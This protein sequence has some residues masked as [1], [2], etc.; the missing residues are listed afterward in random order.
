MTDKEILEI[1]YRITSGYTIIDG[2]IIDT[3]TDILMGESIFLYNKIIKDA[4]FEEFIN[5]REKD[6]ILIIN[7]LW[8]FTDD[9]N[10]KELS[11][12]LDNAKIELFK[13]YGMPKGHLDKIRKQIELIREQQ[14]KKTN[15]KHYLDAFTLRGYAEYIS[16][17]DL[18]SKLIRDINYNSVELDFIEVENILNKY[19]KTLPSLSELREVARSD[20]WRTTW[21]ARK[22]NSFRIVGDE[23]KL[24]IAL[25]R[26][27][28]NIYEN[29]ERPAD[30]VIEDDDM[31]DGWIL[32]Q[33]KKQEQ[34][35]IEQMKANLERK[36][37]NAG[38]IFVF[39]E[40]PKELED[41]DKMNDTRAKVIKKRM[42]LEIE[43]KG[44]AKDMDILEI[45]TEAFNKQR[46]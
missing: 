41:I 1:I 36:Y 43:N 40:N 15:I 33:K 37:S 25:T 46:G 18:F 3:P 28:E 22:S 38:E 9:K 13:A 2:Y 23:Q 20:T 42:E 24:L 44:F 26:M 30:E 17:I 7:R 8:T 5:D 32:V 12:S 14:I 21:S 4:R 34:E 39:S 31:L 35:R 27:Y 6:A 29:V 16:E 11:S 19:K 10:L 45:R